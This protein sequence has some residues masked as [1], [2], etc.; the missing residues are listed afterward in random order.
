MAKSK[1]TKQQKKVCLLQYR[2][3]IK[4]CLQQIKFNKKSCF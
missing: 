1:T 4:K 3:H 2:D